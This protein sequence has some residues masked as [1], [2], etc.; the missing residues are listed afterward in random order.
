MF[1]TAYQILEVSPFASAEEIRLNYRRLVTQN[2]PDHYPAGSQEW[3]V[4]N[5]ICGEINE[6]YQVL[7]DPERRGDYDRKIQTPGGTAPHPRGPVYASAATSPDVTF[8]YADILEAQRAA[9]NFRGQGRRVPFPVPVLF[10]TGWLG[11]RIGQH[12][13]LMLSLIHI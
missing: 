13:M 11:I 7:K 4:A 3:E 10:I 9:R 1:S 12:A 2:H 6:A 5:R 8:D